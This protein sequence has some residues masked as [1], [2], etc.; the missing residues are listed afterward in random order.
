MGK[1]V[2]TKTALTGGGDT[3][4][5]GID[6]NLLNNE[7]Y[8]IVT[9]SGLEYFYVLN[10]DLTTAET[11]PWIICPDKN[12]GTKRWVWHPTG[13]GNWTMARAY[14]AGNQNGVADGSYVK[15]NLDTE[16]YD[17]G[18]NFNIATYRYVAPVSGYY[19]INYGVY[20]VNAGVQ[21][22]HCLATVYAGGASRLRGAV[23][24]GSTSYVEHFFSQGSDLAYIAAATEI[25]LYGWIDT[26]DSSTSTFSSGATGSFLSIYLVSKG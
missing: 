20:F 17:I 25:E 12:Y 9:V 18:G 23:Y 7:D 14:L 6:G 15:V 10:H 19:Q 11:S 8:A 21:I 13:F 1:K 2:Y 4:L 24:N 3:A 16:S 26:A 22:K 5:D